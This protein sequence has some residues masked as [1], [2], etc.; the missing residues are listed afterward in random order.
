MQKPWAR[1][2]VLGRIISQRPFQA[3]ARQGCAKGFAGE[4]T[5]SGVSPPDCQHSAIGIEQGV[6]QIRASLQRIT[7]C[8]GPRKKLSSQ[9]P[10]LAPVIPETC[11]SYPPSSAYARRLPLSPH[12]PYATTSRLRGRLNI[13]LFRSI[14]PP[15]TLFGS[16]MIARSWYRGTHR[17]CEGDEI[18]M[19]SLANSVGRHWGRL[20][21][22]NMARKGL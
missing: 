5:H 22:V 9:T 20:G 17:Q 2:A 12:P 15:S 1:R 4:H 3:L 11:S 18:Y 8:A 16:T 21:A 14:P 10:N 7:Q 13:P 19:R 6:L